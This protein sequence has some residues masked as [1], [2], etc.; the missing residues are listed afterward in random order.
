MNKPTVHFKKE[1][2]AILGVGGYA[3]VQTIDHPTC[4]NTGYVRTSRIV[5]KTSDSHFETNNTIYIG[6]DS[7]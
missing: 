2:A 1:G 5:S 3:V 4:S 7:E 6:V